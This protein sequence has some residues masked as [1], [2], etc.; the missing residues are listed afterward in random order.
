L[1]RE[2]IE[3]FE[4]ARQAYLSLAADEPERFLVIDANQSVEQMQAQI[5]ARINTLLG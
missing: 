5:R 4:A 2:R 3:F 1:E